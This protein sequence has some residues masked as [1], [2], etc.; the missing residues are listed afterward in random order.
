VKLLGAVN[1]ESEFAIVT[2]G[3]KERAQFFAGKQ[4]GTVWGEVAPLGAAVQE[5]PVGVLPARHGRGRE[6]GRP[7]LEGGDERLPHHLHHAGRR[8]ADADARHAHGQGPAG[9]GS[10]RTGTSSG[11]QAFLQGGAL[12][13]YGDFLYGI[14]QTRYGSG[15][16]EA[17]AGPTIGPLLELGLVQ[18]LTAAKNASRA[19]TR[20]SPR[21][22]SRT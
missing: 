14:N 3:W 11:A 8:D 6:H 1:T 19:R 17:L 4:R 2:P 18:P 7:G 12:G 5:L 15:P 13:I 16:I 9:D 10:T 20:T 22:R 21:R